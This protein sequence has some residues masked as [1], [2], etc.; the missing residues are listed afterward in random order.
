M[1]DRRALTQPPT[2]EETRITFVPVPSDWVDHSYVFPA[3]DN[4]VFTVAPKHNAGD[5]AMTTTNLRRSM[6]AY[7]HALAYADPNDPLQDALSDLCSRLRKGDTE[8][9]TDDWVLV[10]KGLHSFPLTP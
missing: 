5:V 1:A 3:V 2:T 7:L 8:L 6:K 10:G 4:V 9:T